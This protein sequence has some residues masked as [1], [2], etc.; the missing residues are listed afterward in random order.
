MQTTESYCHVSYKWVWKALRLPTNKMHA[1]LHFHD[2]KT[3]Q[4]QS[5]CLIRRR[6]GLRICLHSERDKEATRQQLEKERQRK[7]KKDSYVGKETVWIKLRGV[8]LASL[9]QCSHS[10]TTASWILSCCA[11]P[12]ASRDSTTSHTSQLL[13]PATVLRST[14]SRVCVV[15]FV[16]RY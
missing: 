7:R 13:L 14:F 6:A 16:R 1:V 15:C 2:N 11:A 4:M 12:S 10:G 8:T 3:G 5:T 9:V